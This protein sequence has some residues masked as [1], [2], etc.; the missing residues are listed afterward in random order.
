MAT[1]VWFASQLG[2]SARDRP[3]DGWNDWLANRKSA[4]ALE[5]FDLLLMIV[6]SIWRER[7]AFL[8]NGKITPP[9]EIQ[10]R[11]TTWLQKFK[12]WHGKTKSISSREVQKWKKPENHWLK[13]NFDGAWVENE[14]IGG[15][16]VIVR[17]HLG[18]FVA[19]MAMQILGV[20]SL[21]QGRQCC[22]LKKWEANMVR[23]ESDASLVIA[24]LNWIRF[25]I[26]LLWDM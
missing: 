22:L 5:S 17:D 7:N 18:K 12:K 10:Y 8:W 4:L 24:A 21:A 19:A 20:T 1:A 25:Q 9:M 2:L 11:T 6:W 23:F 16:G 15:V 26:F 13:C 14:R 3:Q